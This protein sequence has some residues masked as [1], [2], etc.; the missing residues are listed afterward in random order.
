MRVSECIARVW[1]ACVE[2]QSLS[3]KF[4]LDKEFRYPISVAALS[5]SASGVQK[6]AR[7]SFAHAKPPG[8]KGEV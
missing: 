8:R 4:V 2:S 1:G 6:S 5:A 3:A 7:V